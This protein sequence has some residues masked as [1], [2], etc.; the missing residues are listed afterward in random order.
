MAPPR[1]ALI[2]PNGAG[3]TTLLRLIAGVHRPDA[4]LIRV[5]GDV[6]YDS[7]RSLLR[8][9]EERRVAYVPQGFGACSRT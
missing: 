6:L 4:G 1:L 7:D 2:G 9:P 3:K 8:S 5:G